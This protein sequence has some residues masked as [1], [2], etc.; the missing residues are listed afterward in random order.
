[1]KD[2]RNI[3]LSARN[4]LS[5]LNSEQFALI[6]KWL[7]SEN[8]SY[9]AVIRRCQEQFNVKTGT[10]ALFNFYRHM[11]QRMNTNLIIAGAET[12]NATGE[13]AADAATNASPEQNEEMYQKI[14]KAVGAIAFKKAMDERGAPDHATVRDYTKLLSNARRENLQDKRLA[15]DREKWEFEASEACLKK[16]PELKVISTNARIPYQEKIR[17]IRLKLFGSAT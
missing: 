13:A 8:L 9:K 1:M 10:K 6:E 4:P 2:K 7:F 11:R 14:L 5:A 16:L 15:F 3:K 12:A 17:Q